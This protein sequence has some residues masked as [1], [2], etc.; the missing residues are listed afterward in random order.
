MSNEAAEQYDFEPIKNAFIFKFRD[1]VT[2][3]GFF[4]HH[5]FGEESKIFVPKDKNPTDE[6]A[7]IVDI[8]MVGPECE[9]VSVGDTVVLQ[10]MQWTPSFRLDDQSTDKEDRLWMSNEDQILA[11]IEDDE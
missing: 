11:F 4:K 10:S 1:E 8:V 7:R 9:I 2:R 6:Y 5:G 3:D